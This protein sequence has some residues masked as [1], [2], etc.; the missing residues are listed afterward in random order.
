ML[1]KRLKRHNALGASAL[2]LLLWS[3]APVTLAAGLSQLER[4]YDELAILSDAPLRTLDR[5]P[6]YL[7]QRHQGQDGADMTAELIRCE[8]QLSALVASNRQLNP[9]L[10]N[11]LCSENERIP[12]DYAGL[13][14][15]LIGIPSMQCENQWFDALTPAQWESVQPQLARINSL[16]FDCTQA[17]ESLARGGRLRESSAQTTGRLIRLSRLVFT[18]QW[19]ATLSTLPDEVAFALVERERQ[20]DQCER[21][22]TQQLGAVD[23]K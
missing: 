17:L 1:N 4:C 15:Y 12:R 6:A 23:V 22:L 10:L 7:L 13:Q 16:E 19:Q 18:A 5:Y 9:G 8:S 2:I 21:L 14:T 20:L 3:L 11:R